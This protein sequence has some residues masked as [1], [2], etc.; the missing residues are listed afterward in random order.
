MHTSSHNDLMNYTN[1]ALATFRAERRDVMKAFGDLAKAAMK[2]G[3][4]GAK[5][6]ELIALAIGISQHCSACIAFHTKALVRLGATRDEI[7]DVL[8]ICVYMG[9]GPNLMYSAEALK[10]FDELSLNQT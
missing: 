1:E 6:K 2:D 8:A 10:A 5:Q 9:G 3:A 4:I 7:E